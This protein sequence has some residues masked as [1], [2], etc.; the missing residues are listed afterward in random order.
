[1]GKSKGKSLA[2]KQALKYFLI[3]VVALAGLFLGKILWNLE[4]IVHWWG[5]GITA[6]I[7]LIAVIFDALSAKDVIPIF[8]R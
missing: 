2:T 1:M 7:I 4:P 3:I 5:F 8:T 6:T